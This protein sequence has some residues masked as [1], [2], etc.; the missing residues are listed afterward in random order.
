MRSR[1]VREGFRRIGIVLAMILSLPIFF[2]LWSWIVLGH[3]PP[4]S[5]YLLLLAGGAF[6]L[7]VSAI[8]WIIAGFSGEDESQSG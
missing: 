1:R 6:A 3:T 7:A 5:A 4:R 2:G 8:E